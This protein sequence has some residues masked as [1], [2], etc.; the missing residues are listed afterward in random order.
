[1]FHNRVLNYELK[2]VLLVNS[3]FDIKIN[4]A[5]QKQV[6]LQKQKSMKPDFYANER[7]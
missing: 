6:R 4:A 3:G 5:V 1:M 2:S 7:A